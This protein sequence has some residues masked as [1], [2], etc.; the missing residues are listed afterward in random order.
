M[1]LIIN[2]IIFLL[3]LFFYLHIVFH[4]KTCDDLEI[5]QI[6]TPSKEELEEVCDL[7]QPLIFSMDNRLNTIIKKENLLDNYGAFDIKIRNIKEEL[8]DENELYINL[9]L[10]NATSLIDRDDKSK[11]ICENN[12]DFI[13]ETTLQKVFNQNDLFLRPSMVA[14]CNY[15]IMFGSKGAATPFRYELAY[16]NYFLVTEGKVKIRLA[17]PKSK[18][19]LDVINDYENFEFRSPVDPWNPQKK[20]LNEFDK[21]KCLDIEVIE[22][23]LVYIPPYWFYSIQYSEP[24]TVCS[25]KYKPYMNILAICPNLFMQFLQNKNIKRNSVGLAESLSSLKKIK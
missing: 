6:D 17:P 20:Y 13:E 12:A 22:G 21:I 4:L 15:D 11:Y 5:Y 16:R 19:Y 18:K 23:Q 25:L 14:T 1:N 9:V 7:R 10:N 2:T 24:S 3:V 8:D